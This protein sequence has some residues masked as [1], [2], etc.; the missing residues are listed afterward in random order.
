MKKGDTHGREYV[1]IIGLSIP[2]CFSNKIATTLF[3]LE[4]KT[5]GHISFLQDNAF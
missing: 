2:L 1:Y 3:F 5:Q 4:K